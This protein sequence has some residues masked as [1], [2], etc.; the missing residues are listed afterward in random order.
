MILDSVFNTFQ[1]SH[2]IN[3]D[4][5]HEG[6]WCG[7]IPIGAAARKV[8]TTGLKWN[9]G[10]KLRNFLNYCLLPKVYDGTDIKD[11]CLFYLY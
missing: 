2:V 11:L 9:L 8:Y 4:T 1:G 5:G 7:L 6:D 10:K 3:V